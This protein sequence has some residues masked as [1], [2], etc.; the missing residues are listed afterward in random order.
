M[1]ERTSMTAGHRLLSTVVARGDRR[2]RGRLNDLE[3]RQRSAL[4]R[5]LRRVAS[6]DAG[7][8]REV[9]RNWRWEDFSRLLPVTDYSDWRAEIDLQR[10]RGSSSLIA[11][12]V[13]RYQPTSG[14]SSAVKWIPYTRHF[15]RELDGAISPW[16]A[17]LYRRW[18]A[19][20][21]GRHYWSMS[22]IPTALRREMNAD[23]NDDMKLMSPAKRW[24]A[25]RTQAV[26]QRVSLAETSDDS[27]FTTVACLAAERDLTLLSVWSPTFGLGLLEAMSNWREELADVLS[28]GDWGARTASV[29]GVPCPRSDRAARL[30][31]QWD[32]RVSAEF[33]RELWPSLTLVSAW[34]TAA[35]RFWAERLQQ[36]LPQADFQ[37]KG[38]WATEG[39]V[40]IPYG[41]QF[42]LAHQ[43]HVYEF[44]DVQDNRVLAPWQLREG[45]DVM[46]VLSTS[47]GL[48]RYR[49]NDVVRV[50]DFL[51]QVPCLRFLGRNDGTDMVG[52]KLDVALVQQ[53]LEEVDYRGL[54]RPVSLV[55]LDD[56]GDGR[57]GYVLLLE[58]EGGTPGSEALQGQL[59]STARQLEHRLLRNFHYRLARDLE[60]LAPVSCIC[61]PRMRDLYLDQCRQRGMIEGNIKLEAL[62]HWE[63]GIPGVLRDSRTIASRENRSPVASVAEVP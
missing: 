3:G 17:D 35:S 45:Q 25:G 36:L 34:D 32:G 19:I 33:F 59:L 9:G 29:A 22:W 30:L 51:G 61:H 4:H 20:G 28:R 5:L 52:E 37:G 18:P 40:T 15:L 55:A 31:A 12:P 6:S 42:V 7:R 47:S 50:E 39:V 62:C 63:G 13:E 41:N 56:A 10:S 21:G 49:M 2:F 43:S 8:V 53:A 57:P 60:Q 14:S 46:P 44:Q 11:S 24:L 16:I 26:S 58:P 23:V 54:L 38:L 48:L 27:L 1:S